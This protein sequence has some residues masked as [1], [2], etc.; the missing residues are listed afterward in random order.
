MANFKLAR[1]RPRPRLR[2]PRPEV[3]KSRIE[4]L[5]IQLKVCVAAV[6]N[7]GFVQVSTIPKGN[8]LPSMGL[9]V[10]GRSTTFF[11]DSK[12]IPWQWALKMMPK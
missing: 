11:G 4:G 6:A 2:F 8:A 3:C 10:Q 7:G 12:P 1:P 9:G 5:E